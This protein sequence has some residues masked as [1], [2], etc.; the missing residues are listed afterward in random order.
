MATHTGRFAVR[1]TSPVASVAG[2]GQTTASP[3]STTSALPCLQCSSASPW[4]GGPLSC[5]MYV[6]GELLVLHYDVIVV[7]G[8]GQVRYF[9][10][11]V[12]A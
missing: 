6:F 1:R 10:V 4:R 8:M 5:I 2:K 12:C 11:I 9:C 3:A 7:F